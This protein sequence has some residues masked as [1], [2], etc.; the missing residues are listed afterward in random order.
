MQSITHLKSKSLVPRELDQQH[1]VLVVLCHGLGLG[2][3]PAR[4]EGLDQVRDG[5]PLHTDL[6]AQHVVA[7]LQGAGRDPEPM[8]VQNA[9]EGATKLPHVDHDLSRPLLG[10]GQE[11][12]RVPRD[13][14]V[15]S[16]PRAK[17]QQWDGR[18]K[19][20][21]QATLGPLH[22]GLAVFRDRA[23]HHRLLLDQGLEDLPLPVH[24]GA[25][26]L[27]LQ[28]L[29]VEQHVDSEEPVLP[30]LR[31]EQGRGAVDLEFPDRCGA[32]VVQHDEGRPQPVQLE[33][34]L[35]AL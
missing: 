16:A 22:H 9:G 32:L 10:P 4:R 8:G 27:L 30:R 35:P 14:V 18:P 25:E 6:R 7:D 13:G 20:V 31:A 12:P 34:E 5:L 1:G 3:Q 23:H 26:L 24:S 29:R 15:R 11:P 28:A 19:G 17:G 21:S 33:L 2:V